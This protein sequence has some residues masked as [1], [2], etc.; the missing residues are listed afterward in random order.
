MSD[1]KEIVT[2]DMT[3]ATVPWP[4]DATLMPQVIKDKKN[5]EETLIPIVDSKPHPDNTTT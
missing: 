5:D 1:N 3:N 2:E 4:G